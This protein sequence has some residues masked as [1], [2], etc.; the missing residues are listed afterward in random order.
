MNAYCVVSIEEY[1]Q[2]SKSAIAVMIIKQ[3]MTCGCKHCLWLKSICYMPTS[4]DCHL[5]YI[6]KTQNDGS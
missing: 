2:Y 3:A 5:C 6:L 1:R 4:C